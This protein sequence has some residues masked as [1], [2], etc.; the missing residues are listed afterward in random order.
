MK[1]N[2]QVRVQK[3]LIQNAF[4]PC[5][6]HVNYACLIADNSQQTQICIAYTARS[7]VENRNKEKKKKLY[8]NNY[9]Q[10]DFIFCNESKQSTYLHLEKTNLEL[11]PVCKT[12]TYAG[13][14]RAQEHKRLEIVCETY[15]R[16]RALHIILLSIYYYV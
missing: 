10:T 14:K 15:A 7:K 3:S 4:S 16:I 11:S 13:V 5:M 8:K 12:S 6:S 9:N 1:D 2:V